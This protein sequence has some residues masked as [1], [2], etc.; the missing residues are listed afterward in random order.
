MNVPDELR[1]RLK[2]AIE[3]YDYYKTGYGSTA[4]WKNTIEKL[5]DCARILLNGCET[6]EQYFDRILPD[7]DFDYYTDLCCR[8][9]D[10]RISA[11]DY[12]DYTEDACGKCWE[13]VYEMSLKGE[14]NGTVES[15]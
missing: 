5:V 3:E 9:L 13:R 4:E 12:C 15:D 8:K 6:I 1:K 2:S 10:R 7:L 11:P 14:E